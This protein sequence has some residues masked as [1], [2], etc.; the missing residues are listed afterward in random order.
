MP[1]QSRKQ[2]YNDF[3]MTDALGTERVRRGGTG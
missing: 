1:G 2:S 3:I